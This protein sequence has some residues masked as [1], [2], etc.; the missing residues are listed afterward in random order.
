[1]AADPPVAVPHGRPFQI[2]GALE[3]RV[4]AEPFLEPQHGLLQAL[5]LFQTGG[6][7][8]KV[9]L[10]DALVPHHPVCGEGQAADCQ[11]GVCDAVEQRGRFFL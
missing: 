10:E 6:V 2:V 1:M 4:F 3:H 11:P 7:G 5:F 9:G 8:E